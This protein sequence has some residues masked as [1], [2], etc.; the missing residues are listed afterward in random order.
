MKGFEKV[1][2]ASG[3]SPV[4]DLGTQTMPSKGLQALIGKDDNNSFFDSLDRAVSKTRVRFTYFRYFIC[5][6]W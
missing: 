6:K 5:N 1:L 4:H 3:A 2:K